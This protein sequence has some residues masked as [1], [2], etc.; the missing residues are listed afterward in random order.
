MKRVYMATRV[1][2][3]WHW[4]NATGF[5]LL[6]LSGMNI[7]FARDFNVFGSLSTAVAVHNA[8]GVIV[9]LDW[10][11][12]AV[13]MLR[14][15]RIRY[16]LP[17][18]E[19]LAGGVLRQARFYL[20]GIFRGEAHPFDEGEARKF[21]PLQ[22]WTYL[23][24]MAVIVPLQILTGLWLLYL[25]LAWRHAGTG[26]L[27]ALGVSHTILA[28]FLTA[29]LVGHLYLATTGETPWAH[30]KMMLTGFAEDPAE[31]PAPDQGIQS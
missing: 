22:K 7:H 3:A 11:V 21:N 28:I 9:A 27:R 8:A 18:R 29:F 15:R 2:R 30:F 24:I 23:G 6:V 25:I 13:Y 17:G 5:V 12:W 4:S 19:D 20:L 10:L 16:Y 31:P 26:A 1:E 14:S